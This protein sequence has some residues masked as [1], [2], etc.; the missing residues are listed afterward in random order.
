MAIKWTPVDYQRHAIRE[1]WV[2]GL[3]VPAPEII[4]GEVHQTEYMHDMFIFQM[5]WP[6][7]RTLT[8]ATGWLVQCCWGAS[9]QQGWFYGYVTSV[10][11]IESRAQ[12]ASNQRTVQFVC[13]GPTSLM[14]SGQQRYFPGM[15]ADN[16]AKLVVRPYRLAM[17]ADHHT[18]LWPQLVQSGR[19]DW[20]FLVYLAKA[21]GFVL[22]S[23]KVTVFFIDPL[24]I[25]QNTG[26]AVPVVA[27]ESDSSNPTVVNGSISVG[28]KSNLVEFTHT[29]VQSQDMNG[30]PVYSSGASD[31]RLS[32]LGANT[33]QP[34]T[35]RYDADMVPQDALHAQVITNSA[36]RP[37]KWPMQSDQFCKGD[38]R[39]RPGVCVA[40]HVGDNH[41]SG[42]W[43]TRAVVHQLGR[44]GYTMQLCLARDATTNS[45]YPTPTI[46]SGDRSGPL[47]AVAAPVVTNGK[48]A[49]V[50]SS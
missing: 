35:S 36:N 44:S 6:D 29:I 22:T 34:L 5:V 13:L 12:A 14:Q 24:R 3:R 26:V 9:V 8:D 33:V 10:S 46:T 48:W 39:V 23:N 21:I 4:R 18:Y 7:V 41:I 27:V 45:P 49:S 16:V 1:I 15:S 2:N 43:I 25:V 30:A 20:Q 38:G 42:L 28:Q 11:I 19:T 32:L 40:L 31:N 50:W 47:N 17:V 37:E